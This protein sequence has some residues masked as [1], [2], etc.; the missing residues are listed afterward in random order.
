VQPLLILALGVQK[1]SLGDL[2]PNLKLTGNN[3]LA[4]LTRSFASMTEQLAQARVAEQ[5]AER[6]KA[7]NEVAQRV[8]HEIKNPLTPIQLSAERLS[9]KLADKLDGADAAL[10]NKSVKTIVD[11]VD[12]MKRLVN[13][14]RDYARLPAA[15]LKP[16]ALQ[17]AVQ[18]ALQLFEHELQTGLISFDPM[19]W[20]DG[21]DLIEG[22]AQ[23]LVQA[24]HNLL[25]NA[26]EAVGGNEPSIAEGAKTIQPKPATQPKPAVHIK[27][28]LIGKNEQDK[29]P[30]GWVFCEI[31]DNGPGFAPAILA[32][33]FEPYNTTKPKGTGLG[34][35]VVRK[36]IQEHK[37]EI[38]LSNREGVA[39]AV[40]CILGAVIR[41]T[42]P[43]ISK[44]NGA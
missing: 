1:V 31:S 37:G 29:A 26:I 6:V 32:R 44:G 20:T 16:M 36:T 18:D 38:V 24:I 41:L 15:E 23:Q 22:D 21:E 43:H 27:L 5:K 40:P 33:A 7:W 39:E 10:L 8:A 28:G 2:S 9:L 30:P 12:A 3:E 4:D 42:F 17:S 13:E 19:P 35:A 14:F 11:Q 25:Q 34:L